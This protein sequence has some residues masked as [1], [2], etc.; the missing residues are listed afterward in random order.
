MEPRTTDP[1]APQLREAEQTLEEVLDDAC[2]ARPVQSADTGELIRIEEML[3]IASDAAKRAI[4]IRRR[5][6]QR[7]SGGT[8]GA[9]AQSR[10]ASAQMT[11]LEEATRGT[12]RVFT[13]E[14]GEQWDVWAV[15]PKAR[16]TPGSVLMGS[17]KDGWLCLESASQKRRLSPIPPEWESLSEDELRSLCD[18]ASVVPARTAG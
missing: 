18:K 10:G 1:L 8:A 16:N 3:A 6:A 17:F 12:H 11:G 4:S 7:R 14:G 9:E 15:Y 13:G 5:R 2:A